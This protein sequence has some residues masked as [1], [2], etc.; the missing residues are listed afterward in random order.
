MIGL[1]TL[2][3]CLHPTPPGPSPAEQRAAVQAPVVLAIDGALSTTVQVTVRAGSSEDPTGQEGLAH[4]TAAMIVEAGTPELDP[5]EVSETLYALGSELEWVVDRDLVTFRARCLAEDAPVLVDL[6]GEM[7]VHPRWDD[8][9]LE[10]LVDEA[11]ADLEIGLLESDEGLGDRVLDNWLHEGHPYGH[12]EQGRLGVVAGL[13]LEDVQ[14]FHRQHYVRS[15]VFTGLAGAVDEDLRAGL[16]SDLEDLPATWSEPAVPKPRPLVSGRSLLVVERETRSTGIHFGHPLEVD[17][18]HADYPALRLAMT[19]F[20][21]HRESHGRL[22]QALRET[23]GLN[24]GDYAYVEHYRQIGWS[25]TQELGTTR[26]QPHF[27]V[28]LRPTTP[29]NGPFALKLAVAMTEEL[30][31]DGLAPDELAEV[32]SRVSLG[33]PLEARTPG[34]RLGFALDALA[35]DHPDLL[36]ALPDAVAGLTEAEVDEALSRHVRPQDLRIVVVTDDADAFIAAL[37]GSE[38]TPP[39]YEG[40]DPDAA[41]AAR[42]ADIAGRALALDEVLVVPAEGIF[43]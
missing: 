35:L 15:T 31:A 3:A 5:T 11:V 13:G 26:T 30:V 16:A 40:I 28:W 9:A 43:R 41:T 34:R 22:Y 12:V 32:A 18:A 24:Y 42:D 27:S 20:G 8:D 33:M 29:D 39:V 6:V 2:A 7:V 36:L 37:T 38:P 23:R 14:A 19:A 25:P 17:R 21:E 10:R 1:A 4:L